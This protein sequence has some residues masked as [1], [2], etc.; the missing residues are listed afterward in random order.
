PGGSYD[1]LY[2]ADWEFTGNG[3]LDAC[4]GM[5]HN[6]TYAYYVIDTFPW[7]IACHTGTPDSSFVRPGLR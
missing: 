1:G 5:T 4:N 7:M 6:G 2:R 3:D